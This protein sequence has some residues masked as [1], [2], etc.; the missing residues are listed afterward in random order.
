MIEEKIEETIETKV[1]EVTTETPIGEETSEETQDSKEPVE[2]VEDVKAQRDKLYKRLKDQERD[3]KELK[4]QKSTIVPG[5]VDV[6]ALSEKMAALS[7]LSADERNRLIREAKVQ[8]T[9]LSDARKSQDFKFWRSAYRDEL[10]KNKSPEP[11]TKQSLTSAEKPWDEKSENE[12]I[13]WA[14]NIKILDPKTGEL[15]P[16]RILPRE[17]YK[18]GK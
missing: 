15:K 4:E 8:G 12:K 9:S 2:T 5:E 11:S 10:K 13:E 16:A 14:K 17:F 18:G 1:E 7:G 3:N 6:V